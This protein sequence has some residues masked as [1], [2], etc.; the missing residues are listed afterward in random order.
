MNKWKDIPCS[1]M[2]KIQIV[3]M[4][5][6]LKAIYKFNALSIKIPMAF[7]IEMEKAILKFVWNHKSQSN[8]EKEYHN[9]WFQTILQSYSKHNSMVLA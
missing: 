7:F 2:G 1:W 3:K 9:S 4:F 8:L 5:I 6:L